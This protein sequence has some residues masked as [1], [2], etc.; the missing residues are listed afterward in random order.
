EIYGGIHVDAE[1]NDGEALL[2]TLGNFHSCEC[3][4]QGQECYCISKGEMHI[5][6][7][8]STIRGP[9]AL[10]YWHVGSKTLWFGRD[11]FGRRSLLVHWPNVKE[12]K[13][14]LSSVSP[15]SKIK[16]SD[17]I[18]DLEELPCGIYS[19]FLGGLKYNSHDTPKQK[20]AMVKKH[21]WSDSLLKELVQWKRIYVDPN[22]S[23]RYHVLPMK[24]IVAR[25]TL[26]AHKVLIALR[27]SVMRRTVSSTIFQ[28]ARI[29]DCAP[30]AILFSG[31]LDSMILAT[32]LD[33]CLNST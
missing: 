12:P 14:V 7:I 5:R 31:G 10:I 32:L 13:F 30:V 16:H 27:E 26:Q 20:N 8:L 29:G 28:S 6:R 4:S 24:E 19:I 23:L 33:E 18:Y 17:T 11:A 3:Y 1:K 22:C 9:W 15:R 25:D 21:G 2:H